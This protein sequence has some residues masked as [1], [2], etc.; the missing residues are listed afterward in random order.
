MPHGRP[1]TAALMPGWS[2][3]AT[4]ARSSES[5]HTCHSRG[6][7]PGAKTPSRREERSAMA[8]HRTGT[9]E[10]WHAA[11]LELL[12]AEKDLMRR[13]DKLARQRQEL[14]WVRIDKEYRFE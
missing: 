6:S 8:K 9:R 13:S 3:Q 4:A 10:E 14:P 1:V 7:I 5:R 2:H 12:D 11:R